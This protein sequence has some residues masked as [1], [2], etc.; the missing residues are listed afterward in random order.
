MARICTRPRNR[1]NQMLRRYI[2]VKPKN[3]LT[4]MYKARVGEFIAS[5]RA[6]LKSQ[7]EL[8]LVETATKLNL[9]VL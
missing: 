4:S 9:P 6:Y 3:E 2:R 7:A 8:R 1:T 5:H